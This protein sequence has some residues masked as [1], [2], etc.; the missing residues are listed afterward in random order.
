MVSLSMT[1]TRYPVMKK[2]MRFVEMMLRLGIGGDIEE[3]KDETENN[4][5]EKNDDAHETK[6]DNENY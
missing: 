6:D 2:M 5:D 3:D 1:I 4:K